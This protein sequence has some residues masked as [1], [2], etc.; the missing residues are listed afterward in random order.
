MQII[1]EVFC[2]LAWINT[3]N[4]NNNNNNNNNDKKYFKTITHLIQKFN[5]WW[6]ARWTCWR[7]EKKIE[8]IAC[9]QAKFRLYNCVKKNPNFLRLPFGLN[10]AQIVRR[11]GKTE[12]ENIPLE[13]ELTRAAMFAAGIT[14]KTGA[15]F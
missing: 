4:N 8:R 15:K 11:E 10:D 3:Y 13:T 14:R 2:N 7:C 12:Q 1:C 6:F 5:Y 9:S